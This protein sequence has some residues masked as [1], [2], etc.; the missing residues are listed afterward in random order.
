M[1]A[2]GPQKTGQ[3]RCAGEYC[4][5][6]CITYVGSVVSAADRL[7]VHGVHSE[8]LCLIYDNEVF[9]LSVRGFYDIIVDL[10]NVP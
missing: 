9:V 5:C 1:T 2:C 6:E 4:R 10:K 3:G 7:A 8:H